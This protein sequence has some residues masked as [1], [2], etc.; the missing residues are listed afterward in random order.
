MEGATTRR[1]SSVER[2]LILTIPH[3]TGPI[4]YVHT[5]FSKD[6]LIGG[7]YM[8]IRK[9]LSGGGIL[10][11]VPTSKGTFIYVILQN[12]SKIGLSAAEL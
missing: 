9:T 10:L 6:I 11:P 3:V 5:K 1:L 12:L 8:P 7:V 2:E 4:F